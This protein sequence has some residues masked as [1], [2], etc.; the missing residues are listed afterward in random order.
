VFAC[1]AI[2]YCKHVLTRRFSH[3]VHGKMCQPASSYTRNTRTHLSEQLHALCRRA[4][5]L[6]PGV[7]ELALVVVAHRRGRVEATRSGLAD[8]VLQLARCAT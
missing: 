7:L 5:S 4:L 3:R 1:S 2:V 6:C 8:C